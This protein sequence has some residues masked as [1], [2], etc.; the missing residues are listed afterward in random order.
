MVSCR[1]EDGSIPDGK[2]SSSPVK[3]ATVTWELST[4]PA[5]SAAD[6]KL[7]PNTHVLTFHHS[8][9]TQELRHA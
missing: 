7:N 4:M 8:E 1:V 5:I 3:T 6:G 9:I 2:R